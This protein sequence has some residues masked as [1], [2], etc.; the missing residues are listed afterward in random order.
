MKTAPI[1]RDFFLNYTQDRLKL[2]EVKQK[3]AISFSHPI[4]LIHLPTV[5]SELGSLTLL[6]PIILNIKIIFNFSS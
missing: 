6:Q 5:Q 4:N 1:Q 3:G 2:Q